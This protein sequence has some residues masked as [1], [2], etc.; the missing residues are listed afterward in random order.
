[1]DQPKYLFSAGQGSAKCNWALLK[2]ARF[3][4]VNSILLYK[5]SYA[6]L[7]C[8]FHEPSNYYD[9]YTNNLS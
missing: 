2:Y 5:I 9:I 3:A 1:M 6:K 8:D 7:Q 4:S